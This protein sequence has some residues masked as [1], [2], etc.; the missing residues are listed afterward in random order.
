MPAAI[1]LWVYRF[2][3]YPVN[4]RKPVA[5]NFDELSKPP[6]R[7]LQKLL[8]KF[9]SV[10]TDDERQRIWYFEEPLN[11]DR[12]EVDGYVRYGTYGF[13]SDFIDSKT[14]TQTYKRESHHYEKIPLYYQFWFPKDQNYGFMLLQSFAGRSCVSYVRDAYRDMF[15]NSNTGFTL[16]FR[17]VVPADLYGSGLTN[18]PVA[19]L[20]FI[21]RVRTGD[22]FANYGET[23]PD[24]VEVE[25]TLRARKAGSFGPFGKLDRAHLAARAGAMFLSNDEKF[26]K[27]AALVKIGGST[28]KVTVFGTS[29]EAGSIDVTDDLDFESSGHPTT[30]S[31]SGIANDI[32][33]NI[34]KTFTRPKR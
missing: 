25:V 23:E 33:V 20:S 9:R 28:R 18:S 14:D 32:L 16:R 26:D 31:I 13:E 34:N 15:M 29:G 22:K 10:V 4:G 21:K 24:E 3:V 11:N 12:V 8:K 5:I 30:E 2:D 7:V 17:K 6:A 27:A 19:G 1:G